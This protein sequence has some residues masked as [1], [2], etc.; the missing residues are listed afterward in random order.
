ME[1]LLIIIL[2]GIVGGGLLALVFIWLKGVPVG[3]GD[4]QRLEP[5]STNMINM[6][7]I[8]VAG[9]GGLGMVAMSIVVATFVPRIRLSMAIG[10]VLG[11]ALAAALIALRRREGPLGSTNF[12]GAHSMLSMETSAPRLKF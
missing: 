2:P 11:G 10:L 6:A 3:A 12:P 7:R 8:R 4:R 9:M 1:P 5:T